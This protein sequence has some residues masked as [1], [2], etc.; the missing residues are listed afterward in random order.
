MVC[1]LPPTTANPLMNAVLPVTI[2]VVGWAV[3]HWLSIRAQEKN[4]HNQLLDRSR[5]DISQ[6]LH[7]Y[8]D[9]LGH[10]S[11]ALRTC[12]T[13]VALERKGFANW[14]LVRKNV[15][16]LISNHRAGAGWIIILEEYEGLFPETRDVRIALV[17]R[18]ME[19]IQLLS[20]LSSDLMG[21][22]FLGEK[23]ER[24]E[25]VAA[26]AEQQLDLV[27]DQE[28]LISD[29]RVHLQNA[30]LS[31]ITGTHVPLRKPLDAARPMIVVGDDGS[32]RIAPA[33]A[34]KA[35]PRTITR[36]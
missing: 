13:N 21:A 5:V 17:G 18:E 32:L 7:A 9:W 20:K 23:L 25:A 30:S 11:G 12:S 34:H 6:A 31:R 15:S 2:A 35:T 19:I 27:D 8:Q 3:S 4:F 22:T 16:D 10:I 36:P 24:R 1:A 28:A 33:S 26:W 29:L 14:D